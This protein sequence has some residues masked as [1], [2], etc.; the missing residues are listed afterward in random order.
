MGACSFRD[1]ARG[2]NMSEAYKNACHEAVS[3]Y[4]NDSY[5]GTISTTSG[6]T[7]LTNEFKR[8]KLSIN[9]FIEKNIDNARKW[10]PALG[11]C[12]EEP[13]GNT[14]KVKSQVE[15]IV[16]SG[17]K[18][19]VLE[20][21]VSEGF[22]G[23]NDIKSFRTKGEA[24]KFARA[25]TEKT[26]NRTCIDMVKVLEKGSPRVAEIKYKKNNNERDGKYVFFGWAAE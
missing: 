14:N 6:V 25:H 8:S 5:N 13:I 12:T 1:S 21:V 20:F 15:N 10:G 3:E 18:K 17:T 7:D 9:E 11:V 26:Q 4:G 2:K 19:W 23:Q 16:T 24:V 22:G